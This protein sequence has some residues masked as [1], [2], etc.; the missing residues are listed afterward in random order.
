MY[1]NTACL[2]DD[3]M[4]FDVTI[5]PQNLSFCFGILMLSDY[6]LSIKL[7]WLKLALIISFLLMLILDVGL[8]D[9]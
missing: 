6:L 5:S 9:I 7:L 2:K 3:L 1:F 4:P 8:M